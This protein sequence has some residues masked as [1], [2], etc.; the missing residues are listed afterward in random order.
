MTMHGF[1]PAISFRWL[2]VSL[3][4]V[5]LISA[6]ILALTG[7]NPINAS[8]SDSPTQTDCTLAAPASVAIS[9]TENGV[10]VRWTM[11]EGSP[12]HCNVVGFSVVA[13]SEQGVIESSIEDPDAR[14]HTLRNLPPS[15]YVL[16]V[17]ARYGES[18]SLPKTSRST[19]V[20]SDCSVELRAEKVET[21]DVHMTWVIG[22][23]EYACH[24]GGLFLEWKK[25]S[26]EIW[27]SHK[28]VL[29]RH[30]RPSG[31]I[32]RFKN[33]GSYDF[34]VRAVDARGA[35]QDILEEDWIHTSNIV[36]IVI[37]EGP[38]GLTTVS[39]ARG[40][41]LVGWDSYSKLDSLSGYKVRYKHVNDFG[42]R[43]LDDLL[44]PNSNSYLIF[45]LKPETQYYWKVAAVGTTRDGNEETLWS[46]FQGMYLWDEDPA[47]WYTYNTPWPV[48]REAYQ[49]VFFMTDTNV[50]RS[51]VKCL[52]DVGEF[53]CPSNTLVHFDTSVAVPSLFQASATSD[54]L[55]HRLVGNV[56]QVSGERASL[57]YDHVQH[58]ISGNHPHGYVLTGL[59]LELRSSA[60][61]TPTIEVTIRMTDSEGEEGV[62][63]GTLPQV[64]VIDSTARLVR[65]E[66]Q[67]DGIILDPGTKYSL[68]VDVTS[69]PSGDATIGTTPSDVDD[70]LADAGWV[71]TDQHKWKRQ[72][73]GDLKHGDTG[74]LKMNLQGFKR[75]P[76][77]VIS[78]K[79]NALNGGD[80]NNGIFIHA[81]ASGGDGVM[82]VSW[83]PVNE[84]AVSPN[85]KVT[86]YVI[87][88]QKEGSDPV[89]VQM[90]YHGIPTRRIEHLE[91]GNYTVWVHPCAN[92][93]D[94]DV[95]AKCMMA[96][97]RP[98]S[99]G[100]EE[101]E[102][103]YEN[104]DGAFLGGS[105]QELR[106]TLSS[107]NTGLPNPPDHV[108]ARRAINDS[109]VEQDGQITVKWRNP[110]P[111]ADGVPI[112]H[113]RVK[114][115]REEGNYPRVLRVDVAPQVPLSVR[116]VPNSHTASGLKSGAAYSISVQS[117]N[118]NGPS[119]WVEL[120]DQVV[121]K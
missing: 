17:R 84:Q 53:P 12:D 47:V 30:Q 78:P 27:T 117:W 95:V 3:M 119:T 21:Y 2:P 87:K 106:V 101:T 118:A 52:L 34:R 61:T 63:V 116:S 102:T 23:G 72:D 74:R 79:M 120:A 5:L 88:Y 83:T 82:T 36:T 91:N 70:D 59:D 7:T 89:W 29:G 18:S 90:G 28:E 31:S 11:P 86:S 112:D 14:S 40:A 26:S 108:E 98:I 10:E 114:Y 32:G 24:A 111:V 46:K 75:Y 69:N 20:P 65:F 50:I 37:V 81:A 45:G 38:T 35:G 100:S 48:Y 105:A 94:S 25:S 92:R 49:I 42:W 107:E 51:S 15:D 73:G 43:E 62:K 1:I 22:N 76:Q 110:K 41:I 99:P 44:P 56:G 93:A 9:E 80:L 33:E 54:P 6:S 113:Y 97:E 19:V 109:G 103:V 16:S 4:T 66:T 96:T 121:A 64:G 55:E 60:A 85:R 13:A 39:D 104:Q 77:P 68:T 8:G 67:G 58:V 57:A 71:I 115:S